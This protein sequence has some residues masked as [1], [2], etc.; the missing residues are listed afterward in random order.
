MHRGGCHGQL[1][2]G[3]T[4]ERLMEALPESFERTKRDSL[5]H[6]AHRVKVEVYV[7]QSVKGARRYFV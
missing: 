6:S 1:E 7:M 5:S 4:R 2:T 3:S